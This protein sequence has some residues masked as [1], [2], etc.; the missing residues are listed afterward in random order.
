MRTV[1]RVLA[2]VI[3]VEVLVQ[4][5]VISFAVFGLG[6]W[7]QEGGVL[8][9]AAMESE[10]TSFTGVVGFMLHG[11][12]GLMVVPVIALLLLV[13]SFFAKVPGGV[14]AAVVVVGLVA[15]QALLGLFGHG[16]PELGLLHG[17]A[18]LLLFGAA[19]D[20]ARRARSAA[21]APAVDGTVAPGRHDAATA[22]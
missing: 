7:I 15:A 16:V 9:K 22:S 5:A 4:A 20:A 3:A 12:N 18:A 17:L 13:V 11:I 1:Y 21:P 6:K 2:L 8:D 19:V 10:T 14:V